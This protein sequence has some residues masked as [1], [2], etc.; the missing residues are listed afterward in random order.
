[1]MVVIVIIFDALIFRCKPSSACCQKGERLATQ[2]G[3]ALSI[4]VWPPPLSLPPAS[5]NPCPTQASPL[6][7]TSSGRSPSTRCRAYQQGAM[8][9][10]INPWDTSKTKEVA[11]FTLCFFDMEFSKFLQSPGLQAYPSQE[12]VYET[13][14]GS[15]VPS[16]ALHTMDAPLIPSSPGPSPGPTSYESL[17]QSTPEQSY[18]SSLP[19]EGAFASFQGSH[20][21]FVGDPGGS[22][23]YHSARSQGSQAYPVGGGGSLG[24]LTAGGGSDLA[25]G[26]DPLMATSRC[27][28]SPDQITM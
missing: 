18:Y 20:Q 9:E 3:R 22:Q 7:L 25:V 28:T 10:E 21:G 16:S 11:K 13:V 15:F 14:P 2:E 8:E 6:L 1:M 4:L 23:G 5:Q 12:P 19:P 17:V 24:F 26:R 27:E